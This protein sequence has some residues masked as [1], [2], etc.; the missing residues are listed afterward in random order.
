MSISKRSVWPAAAGLWIAAVLAGPAA[1]AENVERR[2]NSKV[3]FES[4]DTKL[5]EGFQWA[6][7]QALA[8]V[9]GGDPVGEWYEAALPKR[10]AF[11]MRDVS[12]QALGAQILGLAPV[13]RNMLKKFAV[14]IS[15]SKD[16][17][18][19]WEIDRLDR[20]APVDYKNDKD[21]W[22][23]LPANFDVLHAC[24]RQY[25][26]TGDRTYLDDPVFRNFYDRTVADYVKRWD[27]NGDGTLDSFKEFGRRG[28]GSYNEDPRSRARTAADLLSTHYSA[29]IAYA[30]MCR[31]KGD[32]KTA[33]HYLELAKDLRSRYNEQWWSEQL[34]RF[35]AAVLENG[36]YFSGLIRE[37]Y[38]FPL[39][40]EQMPENGKKLQASLAYLSEISKK[41]RFGVE[42]RSYLAETFYK[43]GWNEDGYRTLRD[44]IDPGLQGR[45]YPE[46]SYAMVGAFAA[47]MMGIGPDAEA[48][49][50]ATLPR[51]VKETSWAAIHHVPVFGNA[52][53]IRH[54]GLTQ[55]QFTNESGPAIQWKASF[56]AASATLLVDGKSVKARQEAAAGQGTQSYVVVKVQ[57]G[58]TVTV[59][60]GA[61]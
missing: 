32:E 6:K 33:A 26:W 46:V 17:C 50:V 12:H 36:S 5:V 8:Y 47:G 9:F 10:E 56:P 60:V 49:Q 1:A 37:S 13:T 14:N 44:M 28:I 2:A 3:T 53:S 42:A 7:K 34:G 57:P 41:E 35:N 59:R 52:V 51:L 61:K 31:M 20:A 43:W 11:C 19:F 18:S 27:K 48:K 21:F 39:Y 25:E 4:S 22:Y 54:D 30:K 58:K 24:Y 40:L 38:I 23:N 16:W 29:Y 45:E 15:D 55:T